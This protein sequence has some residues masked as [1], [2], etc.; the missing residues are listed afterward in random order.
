MQTKQH[1][2]LFFFPNEEPFQFE[3]LCLQLTKNEN[4]LIYSYLFFCFFAIFGGDGAGVK[5]FPL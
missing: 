1:L 2:D 5:V 4:F 3:D